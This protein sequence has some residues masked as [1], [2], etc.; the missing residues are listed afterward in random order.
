[1]TAQELIASQLRKIQGKLFELSASTGLDSEEFIVAFMSGECAA[2]LDRPYDRLQWAGEE[3]ILEEL[4]E[5]HPD[6]PA[7][8]AVWGEEPLFWT[9]YLYRRWHDHTGEPSARIVQMAPPQTML[10]CWPG[11]HTLDPDMAIDRL[12]EGTTAA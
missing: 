2:A 8:G 5:E 7:T 10:A 9:G 11:Y 6:L 3:Y 1:M 4:L 12:I